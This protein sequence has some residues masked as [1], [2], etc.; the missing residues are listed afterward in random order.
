MKY[1]TK[2]WELDAFCYDPHDIKPDWFLKMVE[3]GQAFEYLD[4][5][6]IYAAFHDKRSNHKMFIGDYMTRDVFGRVDVY[7]AKHFTQRA[8]LK[9]DLQD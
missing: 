5:E 8:G 4:A 2:V 1:K 3:T 7:S 6:P 9:D